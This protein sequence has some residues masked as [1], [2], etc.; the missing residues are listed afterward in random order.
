[1]S[2]AITD[3]EE[4][5]MTVGVGAGTHPR[6]VLPGLPSHLAVEWVWACTLACS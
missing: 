3:G 1:M 6:P 2:Y 5:G 4:A